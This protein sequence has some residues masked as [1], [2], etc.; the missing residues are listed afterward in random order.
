MNDIKD[1]I[2]TIIGNQQLLKIQEMCFICYYEKSINTH[3]IKKTVSALNI[4]KIQIISTK[5]SIHEVV[6]LIKN[7]EIFW[8][9]MIEIRLGEYSHYNILKEK[10]QDVKNISSIDSKRILKIND[11]ILLNNETKEL[12]NIQ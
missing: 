11:W 7:N 8:D 1:N 3:I 10:V 4:K 2:K 6:D 12:S 5:D 9:K